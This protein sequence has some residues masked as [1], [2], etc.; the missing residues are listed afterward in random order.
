MGVADCRDLLTEAIDQSAEVLYRI[1]ADI[2]D[3]IDKAV[4]V[5]DAVEQIQGRLL[6][7]M[8]NIR[9]AAIRDARNRMSAQGLAD[10]L[11]ISRARVY[12][13]LAAG[14]GAAGPL[15]IQ[16]RTANG[17]VADAQV[18]WV[19]EVPR[20][21]RRIRV[22]REEIRRRWVE[23]RLTVVVPADSVEV[24]STANDSPVNSAFRSLENQASYALSEADQAVRDRLDRKPDPAQSGANW[25]FQADGESYPRWPHTRYV[26]LRTWWGLG[27]P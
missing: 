9:R 18:A 26:A 4:A 19:V 3:P 20:G 17:G 15:T 8:V 25:H 1:V 22:T 2:P 6:P 11:G 10:R 23:P 24:E 21:T 13:V 7:D 14:Q 12:A 16:Y 5:L 27:D